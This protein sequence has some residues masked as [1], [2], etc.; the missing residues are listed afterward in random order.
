MDSEA[1]GI[2]YWRNGG[3]YWK[4]NK[5]GRN[6]YFKKKRWGEIISFGWHL[7]ETRMEDF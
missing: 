5:M 4:K 3:R 2:F 6:H 7:E 1:L